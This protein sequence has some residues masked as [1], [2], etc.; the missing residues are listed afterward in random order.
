[1]MAFYRSSLPYIIASTTKATSVIEKQPSDPY[2]ASSAAFRKEWSVQFSSAIDVQ[3][4]PAANNPG[5]N[6]GP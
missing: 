5:A 2:C 3:F 1:M 4:T 6:L